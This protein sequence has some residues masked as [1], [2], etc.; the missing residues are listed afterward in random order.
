MIAFL[1]PEAITR[2]VRARFARFAPGETLLSDWLTTEVSSALSAKVRIGTLTLSQRAT[3]LAAYQR[4]F[5]D[6]HIVLSVTASDFRAAA[7]F[8]DRHDLGLRA[9]DALHLAIATEHRSTV[10]T[11]DRRLHTACLALGHPVETVRGALDGEM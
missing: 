1:T 11:L 6:N 10:L 5:L 4:M 3:A 7:R 8:A 9:S 2:A